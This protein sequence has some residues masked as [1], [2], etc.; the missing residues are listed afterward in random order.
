MILFQKKNKKKIM[1]TVRFCS[2]GNHFMH[3]VLQLTEEEHLNYVGGAL[4]PVHHTTWD[5]GCLCGPL[6]LI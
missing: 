3:S 1:E 6:S 2:A 5:S 4:M